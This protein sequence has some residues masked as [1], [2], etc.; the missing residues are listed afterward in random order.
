MSK[1]T[2]T[3]ELGCDALVRRVRSQKW[4]SCHKG[5]VAEIAAKERL[6]AALLS[7]TI[8]MMQ[9]AGI[10]RMACSNGKDF[11]L[12]METGEVITVAAPNK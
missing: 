10:A 12:Q 1:T 5:A 2:D 8:A 7:P 6:L 3:P 9:S 4:T 11:V